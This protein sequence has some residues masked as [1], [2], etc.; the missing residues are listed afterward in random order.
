MTADTLDSS[1]LYAEDVADIMELEI[2]TSGVV[3]PDPKSS[4]EREIEAVD[5]ESC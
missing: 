3:S 2:T 5:K 1:V 4:E